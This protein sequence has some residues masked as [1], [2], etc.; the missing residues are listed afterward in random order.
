MRRML[1]LL[2]LLAG[3]S[4]TMYLYERRPNPGAPI[5]GKLDTVASTMAVAIDGETY[6]GSY[7]GGSKGSNYYA[8]LLLSPSYKTLR[9]EFRGAIGETGNGVCQHGDGRV[10]DLLL[11]P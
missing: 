3:C 2:L 7:R 9:C 5:Q 11:K 8:G 1:L 10:F 6:A 4:Q